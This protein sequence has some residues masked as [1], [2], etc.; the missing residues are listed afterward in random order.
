MAEFNVDDYFAQRSN[1]IAV[2]DGPDPIGD[3]YLQLRN[4]SE[5]KVRQL[6]EMSAISTQ[7]EAANSKSWSGQLSLD[8]ASPTG[9]ATNL[10]A[11]LYAGTI[12][13]AGRLESAPFSLVAG[14]N[15]ANLS[16][17]DIAALAR[18]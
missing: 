12:G 7:R 13:V 17:S 8:P 4:A 16:E 11:S 6:A 18:A 1:A 5:E 15:Q 2:Q 14:I 3:K 10:A 9:K